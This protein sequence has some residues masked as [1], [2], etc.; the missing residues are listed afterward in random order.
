MKAVQLLVNSH[1]PPELRDYNRTLDA[2]G[3]GRLMAHIAQDHPDEYERVS[4]AVSDIGRNASY[5]Q[6]ETLHIGDLLPVIDRDGLLD[7]M[8]AELAAARKADPKKFEENRLRIWQ[9]YS[10]K[11]EKDT[12][13]AALAQGNNLAYSV[14]SGA[15][16]K[17]PQLKAMISTPGLY[18]D[19]QD[20][21]IP[22]FVTRSFA[23][24][25]RPAE[26]LAG[27]FGA[28][29]AVIS[30]KSATARGGD[31]SKQMVQVGA[32]T[33]VTMHDCETRQGIAL[34]VGEP[35]MRGRVLAMETAGIPAGTMIDKRVLKH[36]ADKGVK[37][38]VVRSAMTCDAHEGVCAKCIGGFYN[39]GKLAKIGDAVGITAAQALGEPITQGALNVKHQGG[40]AAGKREYAGFDVI[41]QIAQSPETF[42]DRALVS[43]VD[44]DVQAVEE[45]PQGGKYVIVN[46]HKH[47]VPVGYEINV[48]PGDRVEAGDQ[49]SDGIVDPGDIVRLRGLGEGRKFFS[50]RLNKALADS[51]MGNDLRNSEIL[52]RSAINHVVVEDPEGIG[53]YLPDD[54][55]SYNTLQRQYVPPADTRRMKA[56]QA[57]GKYL[58]SPVLHYTIGTRITPKISRT[59]ADTGISDVHVTDEPPALRPEMSRL[60]TAA[61][62]NPD[63]LAAMHTSYL[64]DQLS[65]AA[66]RGETTDVKENTHFAPRLAIGVGFGKNVEQTGK[67]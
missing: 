22:L 24:G 48:Q 47:Y 45:A 50:E 56:S 3:I 18:T 20:N 65:Y 43:E 8:R 46:G 42:P 61:H 49:L 44:G 1:L 6:G 64:K 15:R 63:W 12:M 26:F 53:P 62:S 59:L 41:N 23:D 58:Q 39:G 4:K 13:K 33:T 38:A 57:H 17:P 37:Q 52:A 25:L 9:K 55:V 27:A 54:V 16:G 30:T 31:F 60:R 35:S 51:G 7:E 66:V 19:Y 28:R 32:N 21:V 14:A 40:L 67:F 29:K 5:N 2:K 10:D 36:F 34:P 11:I